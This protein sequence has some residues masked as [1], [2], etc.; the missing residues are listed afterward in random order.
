[1]VK[2]WNVG[3]WE[4]EISILVDFKMVVRQT[5]V[6]NGSDSDGPVLNKELDQMTSWHLSK[7]YF[8]MIL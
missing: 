1:M 8:S 7:A 2:Y 6:L 3:F 4:V 5:L